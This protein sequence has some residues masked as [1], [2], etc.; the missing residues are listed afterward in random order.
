[1]FIYKRICWITSIISQFFDY[2]D[3][4]LPGSETSRGGGGG[5][6]GG[7]KFLKKGTGLSPAASCVQK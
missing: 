7:A 3:S 2:R 6:G 4:D 5:G 1:M